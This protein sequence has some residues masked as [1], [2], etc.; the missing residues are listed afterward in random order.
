VVFRV[1]LAV[2][3]PLAVAAA[4]ARRRYGRTGAPP[5]DAPPAG[6]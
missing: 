5:A 2:A 3:V 1:A 4:L 6:T